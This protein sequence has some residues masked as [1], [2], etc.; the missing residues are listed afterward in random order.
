MNRLVIVGNGFDLAN[1]LKSRYEDFILAHINA[2]I[3]QVNKTGER[4]TNL[5]YSVVHNRIRIDK[6]EPIST[7]KIKDN[8]SIL[9]IEEFQGASVNY[10]NENDWPIDLKYNFIF[11]IKSAFFNDL[12]SNKNWTDIEF[13]YFQHLRKHKIYNPFIKLLNSEFEFLK[14]EL[15]NYLI[16]EEKNS[17]FNKNLIPFL[18]IAGKPGRLISNEYEYDIQKFTHRKYQEFINLNEVLFLNF[19]YTNVLS[20]FLNT[21]KVLSN[22]YRLINIH[23]KIEKPETIIFGYG[24]EMSPEFRLFSEENNDALIQN[25]K[26]FH[27][28]SESYYNKLLDFIS[29]EFD[30]VVIGHSLGLS[31]RVLLNTIFENENCKFIHLFHTGNDSHFRKRLALGRHFNDSAKFREKL[32]PENPNFKMP[33]D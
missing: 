11:V 18:K 26:S 4:S 19:N 2:S 1:G 29:V 32:L 5:L 8:E 16:Q 33:R 12:I 28:A 10:R 6:I 14:K 13:I 23:G 15:I 22:H 31:D 25:F 3:D 27:Y 21:Q 20:E 9:C 24:D 30:V 7:I 17:N